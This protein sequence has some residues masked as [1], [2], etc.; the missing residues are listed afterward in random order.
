MTKS[1]L[2]VP[3]LLAKL[4][5][6]DECGSYIHA[7]PTFPTFICV[8]TTFMALQSPPVEGRNSESDNQ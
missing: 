5:S 8:R 4:E 7:E 1:L 2:E 3:T 6:I